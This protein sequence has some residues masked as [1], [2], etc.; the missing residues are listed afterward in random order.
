MEVKNRT[1][2][3]GG[4]WGE[5]GSQRGRESRR[6]ASREERKTGCSKAKGGKAVCIRGKRNM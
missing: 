5:G 1:E 3:E 4:R 6:E 2:L